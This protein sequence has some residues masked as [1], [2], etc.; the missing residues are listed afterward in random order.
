M[1]T[2]LQ[3]FWVRE[4]RKWRTRVL[5]GLTYFKVD[6]DVV[7]AVSVNETYP[8]DT[9]EF[10]SATTARGSGSGIGFNAGVDLAWMHRP[11]FGFGGAIRYTRGSV[12]LD[13]AGGGNV[14]TDAGGAQAV[15]G[16]RIAF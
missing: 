9:A 10:R 1:A 5:G 2:H 15:A 13:V 8:Y 11:Q 16:V 12:D 14:S 7:T 4:H 6:Q 3:V